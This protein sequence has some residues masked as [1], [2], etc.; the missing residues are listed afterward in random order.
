[1]TAF[2][3]DNGILIRYNEEE[4]SQKV[5]IPAN[6]TQIGEYAFA[7]CT[8]LREVV[9]PEGVTEIGQY[10]FLKCE[11]LRKITLPGT[12]K[13]ISRFAFWECS[14][15]ESIVIPEQTEII[16]NA[17]FRACE[18]LKSVTLPK[19]MKYLGNSLFSN[20]YSLESISVPEGIEVISQRMFASCQSLKKVSLPSTLREIEEYAFENCSNLKEIV[21]PKGLKKIFRHAFDSCYSLEKAAFSS[22]LEYMGSSA[23]IKTKLLENFSGDYFVVGKGVLVQYRGEQ[24]KAVL[25]PEIKSVGERAFAYHD[26]L[27]QVVL[28]ENLEIIMDYAFEG[29]ENLKSICVPKGVKSIGNSAFLSCKNLS[30]VT[31]GEG[32]EN[33]G[34]D[35]FYDTEL[36]NNKSGDALI[37]NNRLISYC[38]K[39]EEYTLPENITLI[40]GGAFKNS[41]LLKRVYLSDKTTIVCDGA[42]EWCTSLTEA[43]LGKN[44]AHLGENCFDH[45]ENAVIRFSPTKGMYMGENA[46]PM[47]NILSIDF[48]GK[49]FEIKLTGEMPPI[50][51]R[52]EYGENERHL[53]EF[54]KGD[55]AAFGKMSSCL[56]KDMIALTFYDESEECALYIKNE[57]MAVMKRLTDAQD[58]ELMKKL[59]DHK[60]LSDGELEECVE[61]ALNSSDPELRF[62][63]LQYKLADREEPHNN[64]LNRME[65]KF[66]L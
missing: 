30:S 60:L 16:E 26:E 8:S 1:V 56:Y 48:R 28:P 62:I 51:S 9:I 5:V 17:V 50:M 53:Y 12:L 42:F 35:A 37:I 55:L 57:R 6:I 38:S 27:E 58:K 4:P 24:K 19:K 3:T 64:I 10:A 18:M 25:P 2:E 61:Y 39:D 11:G 63:L 66:K 44:I 52:E 47:N 65:E 29:C 59:A 34:K 13:K 23:F 33:I 41:F 7:G 46:V 45:C 15:L 36:F 21:F 40:S 49:H 43:D 54:L 20:C 32:I 22:E 14:F 31:L